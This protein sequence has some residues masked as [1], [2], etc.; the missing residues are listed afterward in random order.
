MIVKNNRLSEIVIKNPGSRLFI[1]APQSHLSLSL[2]TLLTSTSTICS[3]TSLMVSPLVLL[4]NSVLMMLAQLRRLQNLAALKSSLVA[5]QVYYAIAG[6]QNS[7]ESDQIRFAL[8]PQAAAT[9]DF[10]T[11]LT[12]GSGRQS[13]LP[14]VFGGFVE[15]P[16][17][18]PDSWK[19]K[20]YSRSLAQTSNCNR[21]CVYK[22]WLA[23]WS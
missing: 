5:G 19:V 12:Q 15:A 7:L 9:G 13:F 10:I 23:D 20:R 14:E 6:N 1:W 8:T 4:S 18:L 17:L 3:L 11:F 22:H 2:T 16:F 21:C